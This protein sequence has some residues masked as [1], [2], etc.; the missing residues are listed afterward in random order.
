MMNALACS[1]CFGS[2]DAV[3]V[4]A[5]NLGILTLLVV[6]LAVLGGFGALIFNIWRR[7]GS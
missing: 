4:N 7:S 1:V 6:V 3:S 5:L 2:K